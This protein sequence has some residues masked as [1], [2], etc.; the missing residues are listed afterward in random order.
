MNNLEAIHFL[1][2]GRGYFTHAHNFE[3]RDTQS[4]DIHHSERTG[5]EPTSSPP[6]LP[7]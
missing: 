2:P 6:S 4:F 3:I 1:P 5:N 7:F